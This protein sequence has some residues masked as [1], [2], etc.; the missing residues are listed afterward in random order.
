MDSEPII[1]EAP[2]NSVPHEVWVRYKLKEAEFEAKGL[3]DDVKPHAM[4]FLAVVSNGNAEILVP[5]AEVKQITVL[6]G[7]DKP[8]FADTS[9]S[10][11]LIS[12]GSQDHSTA[13]LLTFYL[14]YGWDAT[15]E[16]STLKQHEQLLLISYYLTTYQNVEQLHSETYREAYAL[17]AELPVKE[18]S[19]FT[20]CLNTLIAQEFMLRKA[21]DS[22]VIT[23]KGKN[24][25]QRLI[26][27]EKAE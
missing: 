2:S 6:E 20:A 27:G 25:A 26:A 11:K 5:N 23:Y 15:T 18:P 8:V 17:L 24:A 7:S 1:T 12:N 9:L 10:E 16:K 14:K 19:N 3:P 4:A 13:N 22:Y 21:N